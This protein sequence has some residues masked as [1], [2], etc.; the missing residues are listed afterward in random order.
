M[1]ELSALASDE[2]NFVLVLYAR[3]AATAVSGAS[4][5]VWGACAQQL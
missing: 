5:T 1:H 2:M 3:L 4:H